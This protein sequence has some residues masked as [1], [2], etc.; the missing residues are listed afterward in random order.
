MRI[1][2][3]LT[4]L[5]GLIL[6]PIVT[7]LGIVM[8]RVLLAPT[9]TSVVNGPGSLLERLEEGVPPGVRLPETFNPESFPDMP[10][11][12]P[13]PTELPK[14]LPTEIPKELIPDIIETKPEVETKRKVPLKEAQ[15][16]AKT[17]AVCPEVLKE[18]KSYCK[19]LPVKVEKMNEGEEGGAH[20]ETS[21]VGNK[22]GTVKPIDLVM[23]TRLLEENDEYVAHVATHEWHHVR[24]YLTHQTEP[25]HK[26]LSNAANKYFANRVETK[27]TGT[28]A[29]VELLTDC[30]TALKSG[31]G[32]GPNRG[33]LSGYVAMYAPKAKNMQSFC[34][35]GWIKLYK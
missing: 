1:R 22:P 16:I 20:Y 13:M 3:C 35:D 9:F 34:G 18:F 6:L 30:A 17:R 21:W 12:P 10:K 31:K 29:G 4:L 8:L 27:I 19:S 7:L 15:L 25:K 28:T 5:I 2:S 14:S 33:N 11:L 24:Q 26:E 32:V 23:S